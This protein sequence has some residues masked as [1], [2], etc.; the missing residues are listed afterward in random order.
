MRKNLLEAIQE[1]DPQQAE[2]LANAQPIQLQNYINQYNAKISGEP[3][4]M[5]NQPMGQGVRPGYTPGVNRPP[6]VRNICF[7]FAVGNAC[8]R[9]LYESNVRIDGSSLSND[10]NGN[11]ATTPF[12]PI[13][14]ATLAESNA[15]LNGKYLQ[16]TKCNDGRIVNDAWYGNEPSASLRSSKCIY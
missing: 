3:I 11:V 4:P 1:V 12:D 6:M 5:M 8:T 7:Y 14:T 9:R 15:S 10:A 13:S 2:Q 16:S